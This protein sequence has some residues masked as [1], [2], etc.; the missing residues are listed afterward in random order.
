MNFRSFIR[1]KQKHNLPVHSLSG[2]KK[3]SSPQMLVE[4]LFSTLL[5][6]FHLFQVSVDGCEKKK[7]SSHGI[8]IIFNMLINENIGERK[9]NKKR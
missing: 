6:T 4:T 3:E 1:K 9:Y 7:K 5:N 8:F 2:A